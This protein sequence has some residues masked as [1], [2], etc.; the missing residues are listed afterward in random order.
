MKNLRG[1]DLNL[2]TVFEAVYEERSQS[3]AA[4]RLCMT[5]P[6]VSTALTRLRHLVGDSLFIKNGANK[7][8]PS[9]RA[10]QLYTQIHEALMLVR[11]E[12]ENREVYEPSI[13]QRT[14]VGV[15]GYGSGSV[16]GLPLYERIR[17]QS[18]LSRLTIRGVDPIG[19]IPELLQKQDVDFA[20]HFECFRDNQLE[21][22]L[23][24]QSR[25]VVIAAKNHPRITPQTSLENLMR[26]DFASVCQYAPSN[27][28]PEFKELLTLHRSRIKLEVPSAFILPLVVNSSEMLAITTRRIIACYQQELDLQ[29][30][31]LD[32][33]GAVLDTYLIW[34]RTRQNDPAH[35][36]LRQQI[37]AT[38]EAVTRSEPL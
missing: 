37:E 28:S 11:S 21:Q 1:V 5:Q 38:F 16:F 31:P 10:D 18:P 22:T 13:S 35:Y 14:F 17:Q 27:S 6:A 24:T 12:L 30:L 20:I 3:A 34:H 25:L 4:K 36:W 9:K 33:P 32:V 15:M 23:L 2:L 19:A 29:I 8:A 7:I 26:E